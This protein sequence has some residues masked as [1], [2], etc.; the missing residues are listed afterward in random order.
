MAFPGYLASF[1]SGWGWFSVEKA[2][3]SSVSSEDPV[4][5]GRERDRYLKKG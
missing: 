1:E 5:T 3:C 4:P 2:I